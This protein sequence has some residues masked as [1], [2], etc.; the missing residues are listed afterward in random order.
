MKEAIKIPKP[1]Y[2]RK[3]ISESTL[4]LEATLHPPS[5]RNI[6]ALKTKHPNFN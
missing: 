2:H 5:I 4:P 1:F 6:N 3:E